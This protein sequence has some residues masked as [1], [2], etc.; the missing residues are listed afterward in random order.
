[1]LSTARSLGNM[2]CSH[3]LINLIQC[4]VASGSCELRVWIC[5]Q[6]AGQPVFIT[7]CPLK[8]QSDLEPSG[9]LP[10]WHGVE[11][12]YGWKLLEEITGQLFWTVAP[13]YNAWLCLLR[14]AQAVVKTVTS[15]KIC[16]GAIC[17]KQLL[18]LTQAGVFKL[19]WWVNGNFGVLCYLHHENIASLFP[20]GWCK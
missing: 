7:P 9:S 6:K 17:E 12:K 11:K 1:M 20:A 14:N 4:F 10:E 15:S 19:V 2:A 18:L 8:F 5:S 13:E 16:V 3:L